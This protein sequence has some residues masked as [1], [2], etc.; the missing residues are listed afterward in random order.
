M[1][2]ATDMAGAAPGIRERRGSILIEDAVVLAVEQHDG[3]QCVMRVQC[4]SIAARALPGSFVHLRCASHLAMRRPMSVMRASA[5]DGWLDMLFKIHGTGTALLAR[6][7]PGETISMLGPIGQPFR[8][9][10]YRK[11]PLLIGGGVGIPPMIFLA[12]H[13]RATR[14]PIKP[15]VLM[16]SEVPFPFR[17]RPSRIMIDGLPG[18]VI[19]AMPLLDDWGIASRLA[20]QAG[21]A[22]CY[23]G[24]VT[25]LARSYLDRV[26][27]ARDEVEIYA[28]G[29]TPMLR[30][31]AAL[32]RE[33]ALPAQISLEEYMACAVGGCAGCTVRVETPAGPAMKRV[34]VDGPVFEACQV[35]F[36]AC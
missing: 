13:M 26:P 6:R 33:Y 2:T 10:G 20:S 1:T 16:G 24:F 31:V 35:V 3:E 14:A 19:A 4:P 5:R 17:A 9:D 27:A 8:L 11:R 21:Y 25:D 15:L 36:P 23:A 29:P 12:E 22:G 34:C 7:Q 30:A 28:C 32:A 18:E